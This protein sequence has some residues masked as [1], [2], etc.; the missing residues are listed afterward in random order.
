MHSNIHFVNGQPHVVNV[1][2]NGALYTAI[3]DHHPNFKAIVEALNKAPDSPAVI[4]LFDVA[5]AVSRKFE[6]L[7]D[8]V[9]LRDGQ[10]YF[11][12]DQVN[13]T[14]TD[15]IVRFVN[16]GVNNWKPLVAFMEKVNQ[17]PN[18]NSRDQ[19]FLW[20][21]NGDFTITESGDFVG[22]KGVRASGDGPPT[23]TVQAP[24]KDGV[25]VNGEPTVGYVPN[26]DGAVVE[27]PRSVVDPAEGHHCSV[28]LHV[29]TWDYASSF[30]G[31]V[32]EVHVNP[33]D[34][35]SVTSDSYRQKIR[36]C[37]YTVVKHIEARYN[38]ATSYVDLYDEDDDFS[39]FDEETVDVENDLPFNIGDTVQVVDQTR[40]GK[41]TLIPEGTKGVV[42][43]IIDNVIVKVDVKGYEVNTWMFDRFEKVQSAGDT[44]LNHLS[45]QRYPKGHPKAGQFV[46]KFSMLRGQ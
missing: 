4:D 46:P 6:R 17:N 8:R 31:H 32:L 13:N 2:H 38:T 27:M 16:E 5:Q 35:V 23:S 12:G 44:R 3:A 40:T 42:V 20:L 37:R 41:G 24:A 36:T 29:G 25:T 14:L 10:V 26:P 18:E 11:D 45:Q 19:L 1:L 21:Q 30:T 15:Q 33:R 28:G 22:Y 9:T 34:V 7:T 43:D 39:E